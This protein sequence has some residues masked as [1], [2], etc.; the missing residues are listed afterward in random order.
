MSL[1]LCLATAALWVRSYWCA[2][3]LRHVAPGRSWMQIDEWWIISSRGGMGVMHF[4]AHAFD[5]AP[6]LEGWRYADQSNRSYG[7]LGMWAFYPFGG[8][9]DHPGWHWEPTSPP[10]ADPR[11]LRDAWLLSAPSRSIPP[12]TGFAW[13]RQAKTEE[14]SDFTYQAARNYTSVP[15]ALIVLVTAIAPA[16]WMRRFRRARLLGRRRRMGLC[17]VCGYDLRAS[18]ARCPECGTEAP[19]ACRPV[20][21]R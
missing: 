16:I 19:G 6:Q 20:P 10:P 1:L 18:P 12:W 14:V 21:N 8:E 11:D 7:V 13:E 4:T 9:Q 3:F 2:D 17:L 15:H 5:L